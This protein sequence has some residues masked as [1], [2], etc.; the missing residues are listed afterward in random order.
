M[1]QG[2]AGE[3]AFEK[4]LT[5]I[6]GRQP[7]SGAAA[8]ACLAGKPAG[9]GDRAQRERISVALA[10]VFAEAKSS[11]D[12]LAWLGTSNAFLHS[13]AGRKFALATAQKAATEP[14][15]QAAQSLTKLVESCMH[16]PIEKGHAEARAAVDAIYAI[17][18]ESVRSTVLNPNYLAHARQH[19]VEKGQVLEAIAKKYTREMGVPLESWTL[20]LV[21]RIPDPR[22]MRAGTVLKVPVDPLHTVV[23]K[24][25]FLMAV[26]VGD[27]IVR[28]YWIA[29]GKDNCTPETTF[30]VG[31]KQEKPDWYDSEK[32]KLI[33]YGHHEN[34]LGDFF[35]SFKHDLRRGFG[36]HGTTEPESIGTMASRGCIRMRDEDVREFFR[37]VPRGS[38]VEVR[39]ST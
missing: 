4:V 39:A 3:D 7:S 12:M 8:L 22:G 6:A 5:A 20:A 19:K 23:E 24:S 27:V 25:S 14:A 37:I 32:G 10:S 28:L 9:D 13:E 2:A 30:T 15:E 16:G 26:Y 34:P 36:A 21:N 35:V 1:A 18:R 17:L 29:H 33:P 11:T 38:K 31:E